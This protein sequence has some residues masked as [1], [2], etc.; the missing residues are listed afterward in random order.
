MRIFG[1]DIT[2]AKAT[3]PTTTVVDG[4]RAWYSMLREPWGGAWQ[5]EVEAQRPRDLLS[6]SPVFACVTG[7]ANDIA[8]LRLRIVEE[9][10]SGICTPLPATV[11]QTGVIR[12]PNHYQTQFQ[13]LTS[14]LLSKLLWGNTY[15]LKERDGRG[16][17]TALYILDPQRVTP[18][19]TDSGD[20]YYDI[21]TDHLSGVREKIVVPASAV[22]HDRWNTLWHP[23]MGVPPIYACAM[24]GTMGNKILG[25][26]ATFFG[27][28]SSPSGMLTAPGEIK[29]ETAGRLKKHFEEN[30]G[31]SKLGR[32]FVGGD[33]LNFNSITMKA[34]DAQLVEQLNLAVEDVARSYHY[35]LYKLGGEV[36]QGASIE[37][38]NLGYYTETLQ[39]LIEALESSLDEG[40][41]LMPPRYTEA[42]LDGLMRMD[43]QAKAE[44]TEKLL[45]GVIS[46][47]EAR[48]RF[49]HP[50]VAGGQSPYLQQQNYSLAALDKRDAREDPFAT[51][52]ADAPAPAP[53][54][55]PAAANDEEVDV[56]A[57]AARRALRRH[58]E[59]T[60]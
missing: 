15:A 43:S 8:K 57:E 10:D 36:P 29:E 53:A 52:K 2:R 28:M 46:P 11:P 22:I 19:I 41:G 47:N 49:N 12:R 33:G 18:L 59:A 35:P 20:V 6:F 14:W 54:A 21:A 9:D 39:P 25:N 51:G 38:I 23:L 32:L 34:V 26:S 27:N 50:P 16:V 1:L 5:G 24:S 44:V 13:F 42:D 3:A 56:T 30:F 40:L 7:I 4:P 45:K 48:A 60:A 58:L 55:A 31:G 17:V 37:S